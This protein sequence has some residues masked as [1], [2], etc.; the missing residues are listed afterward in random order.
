MKQ[1]FYKRSTNHYSSLLKNFNSMASLMPFLR[2]SLRETMICKLAIVGKDRDGWEKADEH[3]T[4]LM[5]QEH[6][7]TLE[8]T[9]AA[10]KR[11]SNTFNVLLPMMHL[12][13]PR[14]LRPRSRVKIQR[15]NLRH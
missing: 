1:K 15:L 3:L 6:M 9:E 12:P 4:T 10:L 8:D 7:I 13:R 14:F 11:A 5:D 2:A